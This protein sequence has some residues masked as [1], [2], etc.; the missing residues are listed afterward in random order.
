[1]T[2]TVTT[3][4]SPGRL[5]QSPDPDRLAALRATLRPQFLA[6]A[7]WNPTDQVL[8]PPRRHPL[9]GLR[10]C[11]VIDCGAGVRS[12]Q[13]E[14]CQLCAIAFT[15]AGTSLA[16]FV[17]QPSGRRNKGEMLCGVPGCERPRKVR[18]LC[19]AHFDQRGTKDPN[20][21]DEEFA[22]L[23]GLK[24]FPTFGQCRVVACIRRAGNARLKLCTPHRNRWRTHQREQPTAT[25]E[26]WL[27]RADPI[28][29]DHF[30][31]LKGLPKQVRLELLV[32]LQ[33]RTDEGLKTKL[34]S[35]RALVANL[36][37][38]QVGG[39]DELDPQLITRIQHD[40]TA[41]LRGLCRGV[42]RSLATPETERH[43]DVWDLAVFGLR[44]R[45][46]FTPISQP[47][48]REVTKHWA[49]QDL[50]LHRGRQAYA[51]AKNMTVAVTEFSESLRLARPDRGERPEHL[52]REDIISLGNRLAFKERTDVISARMRLQ[53]T[54]WL[55]RFLTDIRALGLTRPGGPAAGLADDVVLTRADI[56]AEPDPDE[57]GRGLPQW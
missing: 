2:A 35:M 24:P 45:L 42:G 12:P 57:T 21:T 27:A 25:L 23:P 13:R 20:M 51:T 14:L 15:A 38:Q 3:L 47:W 49:E 50:P 8:A 10:K 30:V 39:L 36:R 31:I 5:R 37:A 34:T 17:E 22:E 28:N 32:G 29:I 48:L 1:M 6:E 9:L 16:S 54:R 44:G 19:S 7:G 56:P 53:R 4:R 40:V 11:A 41:L 55:R 18:A 33:A 43:H 26:T 46:D 52:G